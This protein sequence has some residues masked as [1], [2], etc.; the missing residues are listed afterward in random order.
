MISAAQRAEDAYMADCAWR[1]ITPDQ[2]ATPGL[3]ISD[4]CQGKPLPISPK[5]VKLSHIWWVGAD[6][7]V[8]EPCGKQTCR[9]CHPNFSPSVGVTQSN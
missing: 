7:L 5:P 9:V 4:Q 1:G 8:V 2:T 3:E 6:T